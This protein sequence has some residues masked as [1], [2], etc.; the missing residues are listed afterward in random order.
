MPFAV[1]D[2]MDG[3]VSSSTG[4]SSTGTASSGGNGSGV[5]SRYEVASTICK[6]EY[7]GNMF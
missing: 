3:V 7:Y 5:D 1:E 2:D 4:L 6:I